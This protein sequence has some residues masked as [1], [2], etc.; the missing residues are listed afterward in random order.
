MPTARQMRAKA[1]RNM[2]LG[3]KRKSTARKALAIAKQ[4]K[5]FIN[6][7]IENKQINYDNIELDVDSGGVV[8]NSFLK[9]AQGTK[10]GDAQSST[11][12]VGNSVTLMRQQ[13]CFSIN[14][15]N[16]DTLLHDRWNQFRIIIAE[17]LDGNQALTLADI[18]QYPVY[19]DSGPLVFSSPYTTKT[20][21]NRRY[22]IHY[23]RNFELNATAKGAVRVLKKIV[24]WG[25]TGKV[26]SFDG[27]AVAPTDHNMSILFISDSGTLPHP[28]VSYSVRSTY[29]DA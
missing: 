5:K 13:Y 6:K 25:K 8:D 29:K 12:R 10:D 19:A 17:P 18:L 14:G 22:K 26:V 7:T 24:K 1:M 3:P 11:A 9:V 15:L 27:A 20:A 21:T 2:Y 28:T 4:N 23:D 16:P